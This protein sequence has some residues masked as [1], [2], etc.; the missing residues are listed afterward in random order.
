MGL[1]AK[2]V[3]N[4]QDSKSNPAE[5]QDWNQSLGCNLASQVRKAIYVP[6]S[7]NPVALPQNEFDLGDM[8]LSSWRDLERQVVSNP[9][10]C[11]H[12]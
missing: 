10:T 5:Y 11:S 9:T 8:S 7:Q 4:S 3:L 2:L 12:L 6:E 1:F